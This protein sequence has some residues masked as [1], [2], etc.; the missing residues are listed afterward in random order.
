VRLKGECHGENYGGC[1]G[2]LT[3]SAEID[4]ATRDLGDVSFSIRPGF[5]ETI[6]IPI[7]QAS[8]LAIQGAKTLKGTL[9][10]EA[11]DDPRDDPR[12]K[13]D[14]V[15]VQEKTTTDS[16]TLKPDYPACVVPGGLIGKSSRTA[17]AKL[18]ANGCN[19]VVKFKRVTSSKQF[20][21]VV[22]VK[23]KAGT[24]LPGGTRVTLIVG[25]RR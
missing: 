23:P 17:K 22:S 3:L 9:T 24:V 16:I 21:K 14:S 7:S 12:V 5:K 25:R 15:P 18:K 8:V 6:E 10:A 11:R 2:K 20:S 1:F 13:W 4:G 19:N